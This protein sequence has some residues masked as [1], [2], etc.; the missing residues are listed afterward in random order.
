MSGYSLGRR[1]KRSY[2]RKFDWDEARRLRAEGW[3]FQALAA[4]YGVNKSAIERVCKMAAP[5][6]RVEDVTEVLFDR[7]RKKDRCPTCSGWKNLSSR[8]CMDCAN[9]DRLFPMKLE[10]V[11]AQRRAML[12]GVP[13]GR[14][15]KCRGSWGVVEIHGNAS[16][17]RRIDYFEGPAE[18][19]SD[20]ETV[21]VAPSWNV[22]VEGEVQDAEVVA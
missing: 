13:A 5:A 14:I 9:A 12:A 11:P 8:Q 17:Q 16:R 3:T 19:V 21:D 10:R 22:I 4:R 7:T 6:E 1:R 15:V 20:R 2:A 18:I